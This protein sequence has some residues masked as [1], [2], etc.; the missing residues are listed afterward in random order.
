MYRSVSE[1]IYKVYNYTTCMLYQVH[2]HV[3]V[4]TTFVHVHVW[5]CMLMCKQ[6]IVNKLLSNAIIH[7]HVFSEPKS[8][9]YMYMYM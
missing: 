3:N 1:C 6:D 5:T 2:V 4:R 8:T 7:V 9:L